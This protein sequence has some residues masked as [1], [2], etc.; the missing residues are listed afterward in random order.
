M[1]EAFC[2]GTCGG[3]LEVEAIDAVV[4]RKCKYVQ[5][6]WCKIIA[7]V[8]GPDICGGEFA[9]ERESGKIHAGV[10]AKAD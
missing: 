8:V 4:S 6:I 10:L 2:R 7:E 1:L 9:T 5:L 3:R